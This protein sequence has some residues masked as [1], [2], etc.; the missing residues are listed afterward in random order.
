M[1]DLETLGTHASASILAAGLV[2]FTE[3]K[4]IDTYYSPVDLSSC[5]KHGLMP[6]GNTFY[7]WLNQSED[8]RTALQPK[9][10]QSLI[11]VLGEINYFVDSSLSAAKADNLLVWGNGSNFDNKI[12][13]AAYRAVSIKKPWSYKQDRC[14]RTVAALYP[15][16]IPPRPDVKHNALDDAKAQAEH[17]QAI[18]KQH[19]N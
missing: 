19:L 9:K 12:I 8:A 1:I 2:S 10:N 17:L 4:I 15:H 5:M 3:T 18:L 6:D 16:I 13:E 14:Y 7:W 11:E